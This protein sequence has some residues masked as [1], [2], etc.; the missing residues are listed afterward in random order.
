MFVGAC[1]VPLAPQHKHADKHT[2][3]QSHNHTNKHTPTHTNTSTNK[4]TFGC[5]TKQPTVPTKLHAQHRIN[6]PHSGTHKHTHN[7]FAPQHPLTPYL[8]SPR[9]PATA[10]HTQTVV[11]LLLLQCR[12]KQ[13]PNNPTKQNPKGHTTITAA[14]ATSAFSSGSATHV[15]S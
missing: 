1:P 2:H 15:C 5:A 10:P 8:A 14:T 12:A 3:T 13:K 9:L 6:P 7:T 11:L 4:Q